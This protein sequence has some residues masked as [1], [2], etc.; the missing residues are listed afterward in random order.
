MHSFENDFLFLNHDY[1]VAVSG[2]KQT[3]FYL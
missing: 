1:N 2:N 3:S